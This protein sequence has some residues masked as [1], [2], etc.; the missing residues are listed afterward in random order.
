MGTYILL[1][2][3]ATDAVKEPAELDQLSQRISERLRAERL[4]VKWSV[5]YALLGPYDYLD[6]FEAPDNETA[7]RAA[8]IIRSVGHATTEVWPAMPW[9]HLREVL[10]STGT[11]VTGEQEPQEEESQPLDQL[12]ADSFPASDPP[13]WSPGV[14]GDT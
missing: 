13:S 9:A 4:D 3:L 14:L 8:L 6:I 5:T 7:T 11:P 12:L 10:R 2:R 1:T